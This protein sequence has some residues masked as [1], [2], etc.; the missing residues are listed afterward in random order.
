MKM[1]NIQSH[2]IDFSEVA[3]KM[4]TSIEN[5]L[6]EQEAQNRLERYG[7]NELIKEKGKTALQIFIGQFKDFLIY[8]LIFAILISVVIGIYELRRNWIDHDRIG[9]N[10][11]GCRII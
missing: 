3:K 4:E 2:A 6:T 9:R 5:G 10:W 1:E 11:E 7:R 8:L